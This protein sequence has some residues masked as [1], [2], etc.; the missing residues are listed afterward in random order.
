MTF[1][2]PLSDARSNTFWLAVAIHHARVEGAERYDALSHN[3]MPRR[4]LLKRL[5]WCCI[6]RDRTMNLGVRR[7]IHIVST[8]IAK[9]WPTPT[10]D[11]FEDDMGHSRVHTSASQLALSRLFL[12]L[13]DLSVRL[14]GPLQFLYPADDHQ[15]FD[16]N[17][18][19]L[20]R[21]YDYTENLSGWHD[22]VPSLE[23]NQDRGA[24]PCDVTVLFASMLHIYY[25]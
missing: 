4:S 21:I 8:A 19:T 20:Q 1:H 24:L 14:T 25:Q 7:P 13:C 3:E 9:D 18:N 22:R 17:V 5:W 10:L 12:S 16:P 23:I 6:V 11:D 2:V 15:S